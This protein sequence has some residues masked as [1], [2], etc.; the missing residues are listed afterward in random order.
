MDSAEKRLGEAGNPLGCRETGGEMGQVQIGEAG[1]I[2]VLAG[3]GSFD[4]GC[5]DFG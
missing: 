5:L 2:G 3:R 4:D 1:R